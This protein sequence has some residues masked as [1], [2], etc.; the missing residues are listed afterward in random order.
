MQSTAE[1][2]KYHRRRAMLTQ[3]ELA[4][5]AGVGTGTIARLEN[6]TVHD[7]HFSTI[8]KLARVLEV[9]PRDLVDMDLKG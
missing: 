5:A 9:N 7:P 4:K 2:I 3:R 8:K 1:K 6:G